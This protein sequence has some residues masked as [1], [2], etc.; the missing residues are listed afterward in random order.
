MKLVEKEY[1]REVY[2]AEISDIRPSDNGSHL[3]CFGALWDFNHL[4]SQKMAL[5]E[6]RKEP[7]HQHI[8]NKTSI[9]EIVFYLPLF[10]VG[11]SCIGADH[12]IKNGRGS[13]IRVV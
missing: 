6:E 4:T 8:T 7:Y 5:R 9:G 1:P 12:S 13:P 2:L 3:C 10:G 11:E